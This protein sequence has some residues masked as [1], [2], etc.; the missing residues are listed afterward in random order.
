MPGQDT[1]R[2]LGLLGSKLKLKHPF[3]AHSGG[4]KVPGREQA[5]TLVSAKQEMI[6]VEMNSPDP[7]G[8]NKH[9]KRALASPGEAGADE[10]Q[11]ASVLQQKGA[12]GNSGCAVS[13][14]R[15]TKLMRW[16]AGGYLL[17]GGAQGSCRKGLEFLLC[18]FP[19]FL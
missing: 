5:V 15:R 4:I 12:K 9:D 3:R 8:L 2:C 14:W 11:M 7:S 10:A 6:K 1:P 16:K 19:A 13:Y 18:S 17:W